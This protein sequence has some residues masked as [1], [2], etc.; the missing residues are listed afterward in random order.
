L[1]KDPD[2]RSAGALVEAL[3]DKSWIVRTAALK[4]IAERS[5]RKLLKDIEPALDDEKESVRYTGA[6]TVIRLGELMRAPRHKKI[7]H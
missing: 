3:S 1:A 4:A 5:D 2:P 7:R 6:A